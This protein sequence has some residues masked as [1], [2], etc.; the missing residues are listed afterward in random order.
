MLTCFP[1][2]YNDETFYSLC[3]RYSQR[4]AF[5]GKQVVQDYV[6]GNIYFVPSFEFPSQLDAIVARLPPSHTHTAE[7]F[8]IHNSSWPF[9]SRF[10][11]KERQQVVLQIIRSE[12][13]SSVHHLG[14]VASKIG[15]PKM[16]RYCPKCIEQDLLNYKEAYWHRIHQLPGIFVCPI[17][18]GFLKNSTVTR[19]LNGIHTPQ[20]KYCI[21]LSFEPID[22]NNIAHQ[23]QLWLAVEAKW[24]LEHYN[25]N[26]SILTVRSR[27]ISVLKRLGLA[28]SGNEIH[29]GEV[30]QL[31]RQKFDDQLLETLGCQLIGGRENNWVVRSIRRAGSLGQ[32]IYHLLIMKCLGYRAQD[33]FAVPLETLPFGFAPWPCLNPTCPEYRN[34]VIMEAQIAH[35]YNLKG[36]P[37][38]TFACNHCGFI[39]KRIGPDE[40]VNDVYSFSSIDT[41]GTAWKEHLCTLWVNP[42]TTIRQMAEELLV[43]PRTVK[44]KAVEIGLAF[45]PACDP[46]VTIGT[47][48]APTPSNR[49]LSEKTLVRLRNKWLALLDENP[50]EGLRQIQSRDIQLYKRLSRYDSE[51]LSYNLPSDYRN[52]NSKVDEIDWNKIDEGCSLQI[53]AIIDAELDGET[54]PVRLSK[55]RL[56][57]IEGRLGYFTH[58]LERL[59]RTKALVAINTETFE[60]FTIRRLQWLAQHPWEVPFAASRSEL[61]SRLSLQKHIKNPAVEKEFEIVW[62]TFQK[63]RQLI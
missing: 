53:Q 28:N 46:T 7:D 55:R 31:F 59:P 45:P 21:D 40:T 22:E 50:N 17:H 58:N 30:L 19:V 18:R 23:T 35:S 57:N 61:K 39:Y 26:E 16:L 51:W 4:M 14:T 60:M 8:I 27:Y 12:S 5:F 25:S 20:A 3:A 49:S 1:R 43:S 41:Y 63:N 52:I 37:V 48:T 24:L 11:I 54:K 47:S 42:N 33:F 2:P 13:G 34:L 6:F 62:D 29:P 15:L 32:P 9:Y 56:L 44:K 10:M 38:G 36:L